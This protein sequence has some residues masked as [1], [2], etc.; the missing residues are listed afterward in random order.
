MKIEIE[1]F[2]FYVVI[3]GEKC[4]SKKSAFKK[5]NALLQKTDF[6]KGKISGKKVKIFC[7]ETKEYFD[8]ANDAERRFNLILGTVARCASRYKT[9]GKLKTVKGLHFLRVESD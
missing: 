2:P 7:V 9:N 5:I 8:S 1:T 4:L 6:Q 3:N